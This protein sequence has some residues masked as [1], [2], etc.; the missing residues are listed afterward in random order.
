LDAAFLYQKKLKSVTLE[1][2]ISILNVTNTNNVRYSN[3]IRFA[4]DKKSYQSAMGI[5]PLLF[6]SVNF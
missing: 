6:F 2:G 5:T 4:N 3:V 1:T